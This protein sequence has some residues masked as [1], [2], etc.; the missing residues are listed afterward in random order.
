VNWGAILTVLGKELRETL[1]DRRT[2]FVMII[3]PVLMYPALLVIMEQ[4]TIFGQRKLE[5]DA[6]SVTLVRPPAEAVQFI[7]ADAAIAA[8]SADSLPLGLLR[9][10]ETDVILVFPAEWSETATNE[11][12]LLFDRTSDRS[13]YARSVLERRLLEWIDALRVALVEQRGLPTS[14]ATPLYVEQTSIASPQAV[15]A[16]LLGRFLPML[17]IMMTILGAFYPSIDLAAGEKERG[18]LEPLLTVPVHADNLV[19]GKFAAAALMGLTA[20]TLN[21]G[22]MLLTF[23]AGILQL[24]AV[25]E[26]QFQLPITAVLTIFGVLALLAV[27]FSALFIGIAVRCHSFREAQNALTPIYMLGFVP[28][29]LPLFPGLAL[30]FGMA[31]VPV[32]GVAFLFRDLMAGS[33]QLG[34]ATVAVAATIVYTALAL[35]F[36]ARSFG[37][38]EV[39]FGTGA[40]DATLRRRQRG[41]GGIANRIPTPATALI[42]VALAGVLYSYGVRP[43]VR[44]HGEAGLMLAQLL[45]LAAP[46]LL[47]VLFGRFAGRPTLALRVPTLRATS[48]A[49][50]IILGGIPLGWL[51]AWL[52]SFV[53]E[54]PY[55]FLQALQHMVTAEGTSRL[56]WL[57]VLVAVTPAI[58]EE[59]VF[60]GVLLN[61]MRSRLGMA[62]SVGGSAVVFGAFHLSFETA[63]RF[64][65]TLWLGLLLA[66][67]VWE[68]RSVLPAMLMHF[69]NNAAVVLLASTPALRDRFADPTGQPPW[70]LVVVAPLLLILGVRLLRSRPSNREAAAGAPQRPDAAPALRTAEAED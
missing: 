6:V 21:L 69:V 18:T 42:F 62:A 17:L 39:L 1:R 35:A 41:W 30:G 37:R 67:V 46:A 33:A 27:L 34:T 10:G 22:S 24:G 32:A 40:A 26:M 28:A 13:N 50:L 68:S 11:V 58:C 70:L 7:G 44:T 5:A 47:F 64:L 12:T 38:E 36:A 43:L 3:V 63:I 49:L 45:F 8:T 14:F 56:L 25:A 61:G 4:V 52:Q 57:L 2:L 29:I 15:G 59:L 65:P 9:T 55:E 53:L 19:I 48:A 66:Y 31:I 16:Y 20:A 54:I 60:R 51:I 23:Q